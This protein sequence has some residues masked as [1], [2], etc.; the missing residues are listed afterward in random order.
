MTKFCLSHFI[1][2]ELY[3]IWLAFMV[4]MCK[5]IISPEFF[6]H[7]FKMLIFWVVRGVKRHKLVQMTKNSVHHA[8]YL[9][10]H[11]SHDCH[12]WYT[13]VKSYIISSG[14][15]FIFP[16]FWFSGSVWGQKGKKWS[17]MTKTSVCCTA[18]LRNYTSYDC[19][20]WCKCV[21]S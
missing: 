1:S 13:F 8:S 19:H 4:H 11:S 16:K 12:L 15:M 6:F 17:R 21:K 14:V 10:N 20:L 3:I 5:M 7:F 2:L 18:Y 9:R